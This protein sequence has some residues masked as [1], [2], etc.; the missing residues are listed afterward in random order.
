[1]VVPD[2]FFTI[3]CHYSYGSH[4]AGLP[5]W[6]MTVGIAAAEIAY[7]TVAFTRGQEMVLRTEDGPYVLKAQA[8]QGEFM[9]AL[10][11]YMREWQKKF[12]ENLQ[13]ERY[14]DTNWPDQGRT[15][16]KLGVVTDDA[17]LRTLPEQEI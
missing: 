1:M 3:Y 12:I 2:E 16:R 5:F 4:R 8:E 14:V 13:A 7:Y 11:D 15:I 9:A 10:D 6:G 17:D